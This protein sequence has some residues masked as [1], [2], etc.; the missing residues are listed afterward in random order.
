MVLLERAQL[1]GQ[2][3]L[4]D[5]GH[6]PP[7]LAK[8]LRPRLQMEQ[9]HALPLTVDQVE[10]CLD[11]AAWPMGKIPPFHGDFSNSIQTGTSSPNL[12]YLSI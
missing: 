12:Q 1:L 4:G 2:H 7:Q 6:P 5:A 9:D 8:A 3:S 10:R 11:R